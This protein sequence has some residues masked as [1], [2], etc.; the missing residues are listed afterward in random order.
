MSEKKA[1]EHRVIVQPDD[2]TAPVETLFDAARKS[3]RVK[4][5]TLTDPA[6]LAALVRAHARGVAVRV[7]LNPHRSSGDRANDD[8]F[9]A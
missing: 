2:G 7:M 8:S 9:A 3:L 4:Q 1:D 5:F 6:L